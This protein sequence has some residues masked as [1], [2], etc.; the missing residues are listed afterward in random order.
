M[1]F[2]SNAIILKIKQR[3]SNSYIYTLYTY[4]EGLKEVIIFTNQKILCSNL[5]LYRIYFVLFKKGAPWDQIQRLY[6]LFFYPKIEQNPLKM[7]VLEYLSELII[8]Q[9]YSP[10]NCTFIY[11]IFHYTLFQ[12][13]I[14]SNN[15]ILPI[16]ISSLYSLLKFLGWEP[17]LSNCVYTGESLNSENSNLTDSKIGFSA[18]YGGIVKL[19]VLPKQE[20]IGFFNKDEL[21]IFTNDN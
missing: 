4:E 12:L 13:N 16:F 6:P 8:Y 15:M 5:K 2:A 9:L 14:C 20:Y 11:F 3:N 17:E 10:E 18:S 7:I 1:L 21:F 19:N